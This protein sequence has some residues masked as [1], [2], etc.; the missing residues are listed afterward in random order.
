MPLLNRKRIPPAATIPYE[1]KRKRKEVWY[2][3][4]TN[5]VFDNYEEYINKLSLYHQAV[6]ECEVTGRQNL[7]Y[8]QALESERMEGD[9]AEFKFSEVLRK[10]ILARVQFQTIRLDELVDDIMNYFKDN[11][12]V[13]EVVQ[14]T[15]NNNDYFARIVDIIPDSWSMNNESTRQQ[16]PQQQPSS[17][18]VPRQPNGR[19]RFPDAFLHPSEGESNHMLSLGGRMYKV[20]LID[21]KG[22]SLEE[23]IRTVGQYSIRRERESFNRHNVQC[24]IRECFYRDNYVGAPWLIKPNIAQYYCIDST[25]PQHLQEAQNDFLKSNKRRKLMQTRTTDDRMAER[26]AKKEESMLQKA[27]LKEERERQK[28]ERKRQVAVKYPLEDLD[29]PIYRKDPSLNWLLVDMSPQK[30][31]SKEIIIP[32]PSGGRSLRPMPHKESSIPPELFDSFL[33]VWSFLTVFAEPLKVSAYS[34]DEFEGAL[35]H[36]THQPKATVLVEYNA[37]LLN[38]IINER[39]D[40]TSNEIINGDVVDQYIEDLEDQEESDE[41]EDTKE[42]RKPVLPTV[43]RG[44]RDKEHLRISSR[45]DHKE[46]RASTERRGWESSLIGCLNDVATP[47]MIPDL[48]EILQHLVP[49]SNSTAAEREKRYPTLSLKQKLDILGFLVNVVNESNL[50]KNYME[51]CQEQ[52][53]EYRKQKIEL[54]KESKALSF[55]RIEMDKR[56]RA[57]KRARGNNG[58]EEEEEHLD[59]SDSSDHSDNES[60][61][62]DL[63][64]DQNLSREGRHQSRQ[65]KLKQKQ[66]EREEMEHMRK[67][68]HA[69]QR[70]VAKAKN[71]EQKNKANERRKLE[72]EEK[73]LKKKEEHLERCMRRYM[74]LR[75]RPLGKDR[76]YNQY[77]YLDNIGV[78]NTYGTGRLYVHSPTDADIQ[79]LLERDYMTD[80]P[81]RHYG[82]GGG[83]S[84]VLKLMKDQ[85]LVEESE[86]LENRM[87]E[88]ISGNPSEYKGW[89][90]YYSEPEEIEQLLSWLNPKGIRE[91]KLK[92]ELLKQQANIIDSIKKRITA[93]TKPAEP[94]TPKRTTRAKSASKN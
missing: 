14:C 62:S 73:V 49:R 68:V 22:R 24:F 64:E 77:I 86:W 25:L 71:Q 2:L 66:R 39:N 83:R 65:E 44:W 53:S 36:N 50:I 19:L 33:S 52:L 88:L 43:E 16:Q 76:F 89:W 11:Y 75:I 81:E 6:W 7:T 82:Y 27:K 90:K 57:E 35:F 61:E 92:N 94:E 23:Y 37:C 46:L 84:F 26:K 3:R 67:K 30:C 47:D 54:N 41:E 93:S 15:L 48:N 5:E 32:Y 4:S 74:T 60:D 38:V 72:E 8:E 10:K 17:S 87:D 21:E 34:V 91:S 58:E 1:P 69:E 20:Q 12:L 63:S 51:Y 78:S 9:R 79:L 13:G 42:E 56:D 80:L 45:W 55:R 28:E 85:G 31:D 59:S 29:L 40:D 70:E 18:E